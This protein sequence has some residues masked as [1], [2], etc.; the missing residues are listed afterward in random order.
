MEEQSPKVLIADDDVD[1]RDMLRAF[2]TEEGYV[3]LEASNGNE[4]FEVAVNESPDVVILDVMM[5]ARNGFD[6]CRELK[7]DQRTQNSVIVM[8]TVR[9]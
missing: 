9:N 6:V 2:L 3:T 1:F 4:A 7:N 8:L 5:P